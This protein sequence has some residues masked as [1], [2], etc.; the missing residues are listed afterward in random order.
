MYLAL[1]GAG[2]TQARELLRHVEAACDSLRSSSPE[3][4]PLVF[5]CGDLNTPPDTSPCKVDQ[6][7]TASAD[8][9]SSFAGP[10]K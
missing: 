9:G 10:Q 1:T 3:T 4:R 7:L 6:D 8:Q 2:R 5:V